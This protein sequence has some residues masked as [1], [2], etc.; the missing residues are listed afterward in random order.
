M[1]L[2]KYFRAHLHT[3]FK[4]LKK[5]HSFFLICQKACLKVKDCAATNFPKTEDSTLTFYLSLDDHTVPIFQVI[6]TQLLLL[7]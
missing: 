2:P 5:T 4:K 1:N 6:F 3:Q 7:K